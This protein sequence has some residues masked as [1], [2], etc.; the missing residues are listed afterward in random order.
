MTKATAA[1]DRGDRFDFNPGRFVRENIR[2]LHDG[3]EGAIAPLGM[4]A[5]LV[6][7]QLAWLAHPQEFLERMAN[8]SSDLWELQLHT[9]RRLSGQP[10]DDPVAPHPDDVRFAD[11][12]WTD[13]ATWD[14]AKEWYLAFTHNIQD[15]LFDTP[16]LEGKERRRAAFWWRKLL[17]AVAP[18]NY[19]LTNPV[20][21]RKA[22]ETKGE[23]L[24]KGF[25]IFLADAKAGQVRM[26]NTDD[27]HVGENLATTPGSVIFRN[28]LVELIH[29]TPTRPKVQNEPLVIVTPW[30]NKF[31]VL[32]LVPK[33]SMIRFLLDQG[34]DVFITSWKNPDASMRDTTFDDYLTEGI[35]SII[36]VARKFTGA[37]KV[38][39][40]GYCIGGT[41]LAMYM[42]WANKYYGEK[43]VPVSDFTL[44]TTLTDFRKPGD[45]EIFIDEASIRYLTD[46]MARQG[47]LDGK[48]LASSFRLLRS[49]SLIWTY[50]VHGWLYGEPPTPFDVLYWNMDSTRL[51]AAMHSWYLRE[52]YLHNKL[53][54][55]DALTVAGERINLGVIKQPLYA[56]AAV[57]DHIAP[58]AQ[59]YRINNFVIGPKRYVLSSSGHILGIVNPV[60]N[61][62]KRRFWVNDVKHRS[63]TSEQW[64]K[65]AV[66]TE[67]SW[68]PDWMQWL[69]PRMGAEVD[70]RPTANEEFP[71]LIKAPGMYVLEK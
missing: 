20:A 67:G 27:F 13:S 37:E 9:L 41:A 12:I 50:I 39:A 43:K 1:T 66:E 51:P 29:Y 54:Q 34:I 16:G 5:P 61:P 56:V 7:A 31:Y 53:I 52:L 33:K 18:T 19:F 24:K 63:E 48:D 44:F 62:P 69:K 65:Q 25:E 35:G 2:G 15:A 8:L 49:N 11:P 23:S 68:W 28:R 38:H 4:S 22:I 36:D 30:I 17:N 6:H 45:I 60:V 47:Y 64:R 58:W 42:A 70:A 55:P 26:T 14:L 40:V 46:S 10:S 3:I 21:I 32:D 57:D 59:T 71:E